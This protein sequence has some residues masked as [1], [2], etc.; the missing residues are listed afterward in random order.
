MAQSA[1]PHGV[2]S[3]RVTSS[4]P[5]QGQSEERA[6]LL[7]RSAYARSL[8]AQHSNVAQDHHA[9]PRAAEQQPQSA[10]NLEC[11]QV[12]VL[13]RVELVQSLSGG[14]QLQTDIL[15]ARD[16]VADTCVTEFDGA[17]IKNMR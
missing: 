17:S 1:P 7:R 10:Q 15:Q 6:N 9:E 2:S 12:S 8:L 4:Q 5:S 3:C 16:K 11:A 14:C 13:H